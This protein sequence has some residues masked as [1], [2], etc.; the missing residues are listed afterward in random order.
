MREKLFLLMTHL[1]CEERVIKEYWRLLTCD[2]GEIADDSQRR[3]ERLERISQRLES[4]RQRIFSEMI[5]MSEDRVFREKLQEIFDNLTISI[6]EELSG[7]KEAVWGIQ[8]R[9]SGHDLETNKLIADSQEIL[10]ETSKS[11]RH[12]LTENLQVAQGELVC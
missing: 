9:V 11:T 3:L 2:Y 4:R 7:L 10:T 8:A 6:F 12:H 1:S 5:R